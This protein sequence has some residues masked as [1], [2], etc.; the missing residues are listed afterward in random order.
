MMILWVLLLP[1]NGE[2]VELSGRNC[3]LEQEGQLLTCNFPIRDDVEVNVNVHKLV[4]RS[5]E[6]MVT[7]TL[8]GEVR[9]VVVEEG[10]LDLC[11]RI[12]STQPEQPRITIQG[13]T[14]DVSSSILFIWS[15]IRHTFDRIFFPPFH[16]L[17][18][19]MF[20]FFF[21]QEKRDE[22]RSSTKKEV[23]STTKVRYLSTL[24]HMFT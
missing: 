10:T 14:C 4:L 3:I 18:D 5:V 6:E 1:Q 22:V 11:R 19:Y 9:N 17:L 15:T 20:L 7:V 13:K 2:G 24:L 16:Y 12:V 8:H 21:L 23:R